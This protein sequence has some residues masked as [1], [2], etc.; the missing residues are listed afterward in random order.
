MEQDL[1]FTRVVP[2][3]NSVFGVLSPRR[4]LDWIGGSLL[5]ISVMKNT[6]ILSISIIS[7]T[8]NLLLTAQNNPKIPEIF[9]QHPH[10]IPF[11]SHTRSHCYHNNCHNTCYTLVYTR[12]RI[13]SWLC[14]DKPGDP[15]TLR[16]HSVGGFQ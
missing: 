7:Q 8:P 13:I 12:Y 15:E 16:N 2:M 14:S 11:R 5:V 6:K 10:S 3:L 4:G 1:R 9:T